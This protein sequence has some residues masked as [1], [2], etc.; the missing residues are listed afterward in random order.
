[1]LNATEFFALRAAASGVGALACEV[2]EATVEGVSAVAGAAPAAA[3]PALAASSSFLF[4]EAVSV[5]ARL[6]QLDFAAQ[7]ESTAKE[8]LD[9]DVLEQ[10]SVPCMV[11]EAVIDR[12]RLIC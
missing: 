11:P 8:G 10:D 5:L 6:Q 12:D 4:E 7:L 3:P 9:G 2:L 1:M